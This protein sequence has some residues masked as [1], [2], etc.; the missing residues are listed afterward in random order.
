MDDMSEHEVPSAF[1]PS[2]PSAKKP[3]RPYRGRFAPSPTGPLHFG[4]VIT[5]LGSYLQARSQGGEWLVRMED[6]DPPREQAGAADAILRTLEAY[7][8]QWDGT[9][10][11]QS[12]RSDAYRAALQQLQR[13]GDSFPCSCTRSAISTAQRN[14][15]TEHTTDDR[16]DEHDPLP[17]IY[18]G[19]CRHGLPPG[20]TARAIRLRVPSLTD[21]FTDA[22]QGSQHTPLQTEVGDFVIRRAD[23]LFAYHLAV[24]IDDAEQ[25]ISEIVRGTDLLSATPPQ[26]YLQTRLGLPH[27]AYCHLPIATNRQGQKLSK[28]TFAAAIDIHQPGPTLCRAL[29]FLGQ[30]PPLELADA[31]P[32]E[33]LHW[34][35]SHWDLQQVPK[36]AAIPTQ[37]DDTP[38]VT[39]TSR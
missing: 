15:S 21:R 8:L 34:A 18:P 14:P 1:T 35:I 39:G 29:A 28:Q 12:A 2:A 19:T 22:L 33:I 38:P 37:Q 36:R 9:V 11:Y 6:I 5:A 4:S 24:V 27:P 20:T 32:A 17:M 30:Q 23:G 31:A 26:R 7:H 3:A 16:A 13:Q 10:L 25:K